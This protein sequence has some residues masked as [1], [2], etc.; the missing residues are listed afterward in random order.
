MRNLFYYH[1][2]T[3][4][5]YFQ[6]ENRAGIGGIVIASDREHLNTEPTDNIEQIFEFT[7]RIKGRKGITS[8]STEMNAA[9]V[10]LQQLNIWQITNGM[11]ETPNRVVLH[12]DCEAVC[13]AVKEMKLTDVPEPPPNMMARARTTHG[14]INALHR[15]VQLFGD[16]ITQQKLSRNHWLLEIA[17][18]KARDGALSAPT[19]FNTRKRNGTLLEPYTIKGTRSQAN[20]EAIDQ[21]INEHKN[22]TLAV[23]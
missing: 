2:V 13:R 17:H 1:A 15:S 11:D 21:S 18:G 6:G 20:T 14:A 23:A 4:G 8:V 19:V 16:K 9:A 7:F 22:N 3:D 10:A 5:S 12:S